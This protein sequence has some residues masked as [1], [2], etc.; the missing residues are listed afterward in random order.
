MKFKVGCARCYQYKPDKVQK[1]LAEAIERAGGVPELKEQIIVK[2]NVLAPRHPEDAVTT[3]PEVV[4]GLIKVISNALGD[5]KKFI[6]ADN[7]GYIFTEQRDLLFEVTGMAELSREGLAEVELLSDRGLI[8]V[9]N[10]TATNLRYLRVS[11]IWLD[12][13]YSIINVAKLKTHV[14]TLITGCIKNIFGIADR[15]TR[16]EA[17]A[18]INQRQFLEAILDIYTL[19]EPHFHIMDAITVMEGNGPSRGTPKKGGWILA[20]HNALAVDMV[21]AYMMGY[22]N[23]LDVPLLNVAAGRR[24]GPS[25]L[26]E[27]ELVGATFEDLVI[28]DFKKITTFI[29]KIPSF[30]RG[31][32]HSLVY[33]YP[34]LNKNNCLKCGICKKVC[35]VNAIKME[36][37]P[38]IDRSKCVK[39]LCCHEMCPNGSMELRDSMLKKIIGR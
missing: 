33:F 17:H 23:P 12:D 11:K 27:I 13:E 1:A 26:N 28:E 30:L 10:K 34:V 19:R 4:K 18:A 6:V 24:C 9:E 36:P 22:R 31:F 37:F 16:K 29:P 39:C 20:S 38:I 21:S 25:S 8:A 7:P 2:P 5:N 14:E 3:H 35:P 32:A 15:K